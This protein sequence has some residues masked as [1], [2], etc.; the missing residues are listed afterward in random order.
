MP[1]KSNGKK[2]PNCNK[3]VD[4]FEAKCPYCETIINYPGKESD[5]L[6]NERCET[7]YYSNQSGDLICEY[8]LIE[9]KPRGCKIT[10]CKKYK[11]R[12]DSGKKP[13]PLPAKKEWSRECMIV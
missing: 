3:R 7:C 13:I 9:K 2:C 12:E 10:D 11:S 8:I 5:Y 6:C 4:L 1:K